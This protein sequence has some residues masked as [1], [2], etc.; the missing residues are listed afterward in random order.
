MLRIRSLAYPFFALA[1]PTTA[2]AA[3]WSS[4]PAL[5]SAVCVQNGDQTVPQIAAGSDGATW[6][7]W[8]DN[9]SGA[10]AVYA[11]HFDSLGLPSFAANGLAVSTHPQNSSLI[12]WDM[13][14]DAAGNALLAFTDVR[15]GGDLDVY[16]YKLSPSGQFLWGADGVAI[17]TNGDFD[18][19]PVLAEL[20]DGSV[21]IAYARIPSSGTGA[22]HIQRRSSAG[23]LLGESVISGAT[24]EKPSFAALVASD[25]GS[26]IVQWL[27]NT[28]SFSSLR[29]IRAM[30][31]DANGA[32]LWNGG[33]PVIVYDA[34]SVPIAYQPLLESDGAGGAWLAW[35]AAPA[36][37]FTS[38]VQRL[39]ASGAELFPHNGVSVSVEA[40]VQ[41]LSPSIA[42]MANG[43]AIVVFNRRNGAQSQWGVGAQRISAS[44]AR[45]WT[46]PGVSLA[47]LDGQNESFER[48]VAFGDGALALYFDNPQTPIPAS[49]LRAARLN[50]NG[51]FTWMPSG[52]VSVSAILPQKDDLEVLVDRTGV[53]RAAWRD[54]RNDSGD[55]FAQS[56]HAEGALGTGSAC[57]AGAFCNTSPNSVGPGAQLDSLG[58][59]S[60]GW[61]D[62]ELTVSGCP[63][64]V[65]GRFFTSSQVIAPTPFF[66]GTLCL[67]QPLERLA[68]VTTSPSG[69]AATQLAAPS[70]PPAFAVGTTWGFQFWYRD[71]ANPGPSTNTSDGVL[72]FICP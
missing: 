62:F 29:H 67:A 8:F 22:I 19:N 18:A 11:Q 7:G 49:R 9:R 64:G 69:A 33:A 4:D 41:Q 23:A 40:G 10:Y 68:L 16:A 3:Q 13:Q 59:P 26:F 58:A 52:T 46:D 24:N 70:L 36:S 45:L 60:L 28:A 71:P 47:A 35:H 42:P 51:A 48:V 15:A 57:V 32:A 55:I 20:S 17:S 1:A 39:S 6:V 56:L 38:R 65:S 5:N 31:F 53:V 72:A 50:A 44:G 43:E 37:T 25:N 2:L 63:P 54:E 12:G 27:R 14:S 34:S 66:A 21:A 30:K 61:A